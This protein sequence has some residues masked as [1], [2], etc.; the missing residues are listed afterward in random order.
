MYEIEKKNDPK[1]GLVSSV[2]LDSPKER[3][4][5]GLQTEELFQMDPLQ[6][7]F[8]VKFYIDENYKSTSHK[9][10]YTFSISQVIHWTYLFK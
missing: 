1:R 9:S 2:P 3:I 7:Y 6:I 5:K 10:K 8:M 4:K